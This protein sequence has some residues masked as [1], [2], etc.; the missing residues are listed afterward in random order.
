MGI[1]R[2]V[3]NE[4][5]STVSQSTSLL[6]GTLP[7]TPIITPHGRK[8]RQAAAVL[9]RGHTPGVQLSSNWREFFGILTPFSFVAAIT[10]Y[11][12]PRACPTLPSRNPQKPSK[13]QKGRAWGARVGGGEDGKKSRRVVKQMEIVTYAPP[14]SFSTMHPPPPPHH[15]PPLIPP[16]P[17]P[18]PHPSPRVYKRA[19][20]LRG[21]TKGGCHVRQQ[22]C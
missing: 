4:L 19:V 18:P 11:P 12:T 22:A 20:C 14:V 9:V 3:A 16:P 15:H 7:R 21:L 1:L 13:H 6:N 5:L 10:L 17:P 8:L 2:L